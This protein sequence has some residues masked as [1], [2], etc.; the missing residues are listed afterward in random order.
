MWDEIFTVGCCH[1]AWTQQPIVNIP[2]HMD[3]TTYNKYVMPHRPN[4]LQYICH[5]TLTQ[6]PTIHISCHMDTTT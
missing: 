1:A 5:A 2:C 6:Q 3:T 4:N